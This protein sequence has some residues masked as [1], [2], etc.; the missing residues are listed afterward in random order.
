[1]NLHDAIYKRISTRTYKK[2][3]LKESEIFDIKETL[4]RFSNEKG[5][6]GNKIEFSFSLNN[7]DDIDGKKIGTYGFI[8]N[9]PAY[10]GGVTLNTRE[11]IIDFGYL[12]EK[13][14]LEL[15]S[16]DYSTCWL[17]GT[18]KRKDYRKELL[19]NE[20]IPAIAPV[21]H[22]NEKRSMAEK[23]LKLEK[24]SKNRKVFNDMFI[25]VDGS[26][27]ENEAIHQSLE[28]VRLGPSASNKQPWRVLL[29]EKTVHF[30]L[31]RTENYGKMLNY[32]IQL[33]DMG[34][35]LSHFE[36]ELEYQGIEYEKE[37]TK[38]NDKENWEYICS[39]SLSK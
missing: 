3:K 20:I 14:I 12:F 19:E 16:K 29:E 11:S 18:F 38:Q 35:A 4:A 37:T 31:E 6:F 23:L 24:L 1:M 30:Y 33:L 21:G 36:I 15:T 8:K 39:Y 13:I 32:D 7:N 17:G 9:V 25:N 27:I 5:P 10:I 26:L 34:I 28:A 22:R 2:E